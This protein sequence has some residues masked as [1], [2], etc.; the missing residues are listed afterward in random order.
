MLSRISTNIA[1]S[2][3]KADPNTDIE[4]MA[5]SLKNKLNQF[6]AM[7]IALT[8]CIW[9]S[10]WIG[11][12]VSY[13]LLMIIRGRSG[14][15]HLPSLTLCSIASGIFMGVVPIIEYSNNIVF[16]MTIFSVVIFALFAPNYFHER[17]DDGSD[18]RNKIIVTII[19][20]SNLFM[21]S[22]LVATV[23]VVQALTILPWTRR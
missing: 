9:T 6:F 14:G 13:L 20:A 21:L 22:S 17:I 12:I 1:R 15:R 2:I 16:Y 4:L 19:A 5:Y 23:L 8:I 11:V 10:Q 7:A 18:V 3:N